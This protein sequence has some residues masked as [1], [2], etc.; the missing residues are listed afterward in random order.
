[1]APAPITTSGAKRMGL[2]V[3]ALWASKAPDTTP[4]RPYSS[5]IIPA[6]K[7]GLTMKRFPKA[8]KKKTIVPVFRYFMDG[9]KVTQ[10]KVID[11]P[12]KGN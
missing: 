12:C 4:E 6:T 10:E 3:F 7:R 11:N 9:L 5:A 1:M 8:P 2:K